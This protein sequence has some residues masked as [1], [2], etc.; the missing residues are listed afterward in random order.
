MKKE[1]VTDPVRSWRV[2]SS[3]L[4]SSHNHWRK[5]ILLGGYFFPPEPFIFLPNRK[6]TWNPKIKVWK[7]WFSGSMLYKFPGRVVQETSDFIMIYFINPRMFVDRRNT[8]SRETPFHYEFFLKRWCFPKNQ[9]WSL[10][11]TSRKTI[12]ENSGKALG[13]LPSC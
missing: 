1:K 4:I 7:V 5:S 12:N 8:G 3:K 13:I 2:N 9:R 6:L 10:Q 11:L